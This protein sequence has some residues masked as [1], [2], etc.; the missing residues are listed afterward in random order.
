MLS[1]TAPLTASQLLQQFSLHRTQ[2]G[3][4]ACRNLRTQLE[5]LAVHRPLLVR[6][7]FATDASG[8]S[9]E[10]TESLSNGTRCT[11]LDVHSPLAPA[12]VDAFAKVCREGQFDCVVA[13]GGGATMDAAKLISLCASTCKPMMSLLEGIT[14]GNRIPIIAVPTTAGSGSEATHFAVLFVGEEKYSVAHASLRPAVAIVDPTLIA[15]VPPRVAVAAGLDVLCQSIESLWSRNADRKSLAFA[16]EALR[17][18][19]PNLRP[20]IVDADPDAQSAVCLASH[21]AGQAINRSFT[22]ICHALSYMLTARY[23]I[24]HGLAAASTLPAS[25]LFN[26][27]RVGAEHLPCGRDG[28]MDRCLEELSSVLKCNDVESMARQLVVLIRSVGGVAS[29]SELELP[30]QYRPVEHAENFNSDRLRNNPRR[31]TTDDIVGILLKA[32]DNE[33]YV[34][35]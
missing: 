32:F 7:P 26:G 25:L 16:S 19:V 22:T 4:G 18:V 9:D 8:I 11:V 27:E 5:R 31:A 12:D 20:A 23:G 2:F 24:P 33:G 3:E 14:K 21:L 10:L 35:G 6:D 1:P 15:S 17:L 28:A 13:V 34:K 29:V 30:P